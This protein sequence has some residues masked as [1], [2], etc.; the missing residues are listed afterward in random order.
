MDKLTSASRQSLQEKE[1]EIAQLKERLAN[2]KEPA[3]LQIV[4]QG[5]SI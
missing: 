3:P 5:S 1:I 2:K 4:K